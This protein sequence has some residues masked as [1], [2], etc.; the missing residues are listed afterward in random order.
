MLKEQ[1][2]VAV[3]VLSRALQMPHADESEL[4]GVYYHLGRCFEE[5]GNRGE[6]KDAYERVIGLDIQFRDVSERLARL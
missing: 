3:K 4:L 5:L 6:A 1:Y 2:N